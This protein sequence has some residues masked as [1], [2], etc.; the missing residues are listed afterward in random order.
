MRNILPLTIITIIY[1]CSC[2]R[3]QDKSSFTLL[4][5]DSKIVFTVPKDCKNTTSCLQYYAEPDGN[6]FLC[7]LNRDKNKILFYNMNTLEL[8]FEIEMPQKGPNGVG[9]ISSFVIH[10]FDT[11]MLTTGQMNVLYLIDSSGVIKNKYPAD[12]IMNGAY[13]IYYCNS[14]STHR[15]LIIKNGTIYV[16]MHL[17]TFP[18]P[19]EIQ[20]FKICLRINMKNNEQQLLPLA[21][22]PIGSIDKKPVY[23]YFSTHLIDNKFIYNFISSHD[24]Y[25]SK[26]LENFRKVPVKSKFMKKDF[27]LPDLRSGYHSVIKSNLEHGT[28]G[29]FLNDS[30]RNVFYRFAYPGVK[31]NSSIMSLNIPELINLNEFRSVFSIMILDSN[32]EIIGEQLLPENTYNKNM[33]FVNENGLYISTNHPKNPEFNPDSLK[34][35]LFKLGRIKNKDY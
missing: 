24:L 16:G 15:N 21:Y 28:Y 31:M 29:M 9:R 18:D 13:N 32:L 19:E 35:E 34:F 12:N 23:N 26:N 11:I 17:L 25:I 14:P 22:P 8:S 3:N 10:N 1:F 5:T 6:A 33:A 20:L 2:T 7:Y 30:Y 27:L 4:P